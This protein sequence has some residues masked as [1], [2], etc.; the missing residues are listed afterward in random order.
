LILILYNIMLCY[1]DIF[2]FL[3]LFLKITV[4][5]FILN[6]SIDDPDVSQSTLSL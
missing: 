3:Y 4:G 2:I 5:D 1:I 6:F